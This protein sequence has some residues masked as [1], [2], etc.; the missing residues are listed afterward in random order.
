[1][2]SDPEKKSNYDQFGEEGPNHTIN[3]GFHFNEDF[4]FDLFRQM[5]GGDP[6]GGNGKR[7]LLELEIVLA[8]LSF[9]IIITAIDNNCPTYNNAKQCFSWTIVHGGQKI[10]LAQKIHASRG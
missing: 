1:M 5:F 7:T 3:H 6:F 9:L 4:E 8:M 10:E 2:L